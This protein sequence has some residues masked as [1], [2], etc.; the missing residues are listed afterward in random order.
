MQQVQS[1]AYKLWLLTRTISIYSIRV[2]RLVT[3]SNTQA[4]FAFLSYP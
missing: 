3:I 4:L 1:L 2:Y